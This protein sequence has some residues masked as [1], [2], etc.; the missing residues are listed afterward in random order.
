MLENVCPRGD[1][2]PLPQ[3]VHLVTNTYSPKTNRGSLLHDLD[4]SGQI[5]RKIPDLHDL[6]HGAVGAV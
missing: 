4:L 3:A 2:W 6:A 5:D 1:V